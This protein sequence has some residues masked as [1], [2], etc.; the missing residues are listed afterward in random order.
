MIR[1]I[2]LS[3]RIPQI[4]KM[5]KS[6]HDRAEKTSR[7]AVEVEKIESSFSN[8][9][10]EMRSN[11]DGISGI[12]FTVEIDHH[13]TGQSRISDVQMRMILP[14]DY[15]RSLPKVYPVDITIPFDNRAH[16]YRD[17]EGG[18][19]I[20]L[21]TEEEWTEDCTMAG[22]MSLASLWIHKYIVWRNEGVWPGLGRSHCNIC[23]KIGGCEH[24]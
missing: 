19:H 22:L 13:V 8:M 6:D 17:R 4:Q 24:S 5:R 18:V 1:G 20:C 15:P 7:W 10:I 9:E 3:T 11:G 21:I 16:L 2:H 23:G 12:Q 14:D